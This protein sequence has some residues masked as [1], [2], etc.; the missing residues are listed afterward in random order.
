MPLFLTESS[1][2]L[3]GQPVSRST[4]RSVIACAENEI[5]PITDVRGSADYKR[6]LLKRLI[7]AHFLTC[8]P[9]LNTEDLL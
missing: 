2:L 7:A 6:R 3:Q 9:H 8:F 1:A 4:L 5:R